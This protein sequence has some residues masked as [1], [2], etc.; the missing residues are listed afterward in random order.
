ML[1]LVFERKF[2]KD[3]EK[4]KRRNKSMTKL[5][6]LIELLANEKSLT[7]KHCNHKL[8]GNYTD[9][10]ECHIE[11]DWLLIYKKTPIELVLVRTGTHSDLF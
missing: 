3:V 11:P 1:K 9:Y 7:E 10:W 4:A 8:R 5:K 2:K 6:G